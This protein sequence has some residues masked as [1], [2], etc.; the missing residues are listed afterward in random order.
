MVGLVA[1][2]ALAA[3]VGAEAFVPTASPLSRAKETGLRGAEPLDAALDDGL[4]PATILLQVEAIEGE[5][6][7][8]EEEEVGEDEEQEEND[9]TDETHTQ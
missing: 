8:D 6:T 4:V 1:V 3:L 5:H 9:D 7:K 2:V